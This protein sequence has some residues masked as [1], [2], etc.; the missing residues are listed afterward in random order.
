MELNRKLLS[1][2]W[3]LQLSPVV[4]FISTMFIPILFI[5]WLYKVGQLLERKLSL[6]PSYLF[7]VLLTTYSM[8][9]LF[10]ILFP[11][12]GENIQID[13]E[14]YIDYSFWTFYVSFLYC[15]IHIT[16]LLSKHKDN[17]ENEYNSTM[18]EK[19]RLFFTLYFL[20]LGVMTLQPK[21]KDIFNELKHKNES[22]SP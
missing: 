21:V 16:S 11:I 4:V 12:W 5:I 15:T 14:I 7:R 3:I 17:D 18:L 19:V 10:F 22:P 13:R 1:F 6:K 9:L 2:D 20:P 8:G